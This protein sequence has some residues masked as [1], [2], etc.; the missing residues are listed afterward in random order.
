[1][2]VG[3][4][5]AGH[6]LQRG[7]LLE[8][9]HHVPRV[10]QQRLHPGLVVVLPQRVLEIGAGRVDVLDDP[11]GLGQ[12][13]QRCPHPAA[14]PRGGPAQ[15]RRRWLSTTVGES[16]AAFAVEACTRWRFVVEE[17][18]RAGIEAHLAEPADTAAARRPKRRARP[19]TLCAASA[20]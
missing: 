1:M 4:P 6:E 15:D 18:Q 10:L 3:D 2:D 9:A 11:V 12:R 14:G 13:V 19:T 20:A 16:P 17:L 7:V 8:E 5:R